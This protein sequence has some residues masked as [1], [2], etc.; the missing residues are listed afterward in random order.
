MPLPTPQGELAP[1]SS[2]NGPQSQFRAG[3][4]VLSLFSSAQHSL[5]LRRLAHGPVALRD[6]EDTQ[7]ISSPT[8][9]RGNIGNLIGIGALEKRNPDGEPGVLDNALTPFGR[10]LLFVS[11]VL[12]VWLSRAPAE[13]ISSEATSAKEAIRAMVSAWGSTMLRALAVRSLSVSELDDLIG[14]LSYP[15]IAR[16]I[17]AMDDAGLISAVGENG[18][19]PA[20]AP[21][22]WLR[23]A[24]GPLLAAMH[25]E[26]QYL[27][28]WAAPPDRIDVETLF[29]LAL[30]L[31]GSVD[32]VDGTCHLVIQLDGGDDRSDVAGV[33]ATVRGGKPVSCVSTLD[34]APDDWISG[35][36]SRWLT[37]LVE[38]DT[39]ELESGGRNG[40]SVALAEALHRR[41]FDAGGASL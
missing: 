13:P 9:L 6:L 18:K 22:R 27:D 24:T 10:D 11:A 36:A 41:L 34:E 3:G 20:Y 29:L 21:T 19:G 37:A 15:A 28:G 14:S 38:G 8:A 16:R 5:I 39:G 7:G 23:E 40:L 35:P 17:A 31:L 12:D 26:S 33:R 25:C 30:P 2:A 1:T 4:R 32:G